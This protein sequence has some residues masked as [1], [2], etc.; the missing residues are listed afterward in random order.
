MN[1]T[2]HHSDESN[3]GFIRIWTERFWFHFT[4]KLSSFWPLLCFVLLLF[5]LHFTSDMTIL[6]LT[7]RVAFDTSDFSIRSTVSAT[8][9]NFVSLRREE[10][11][12]SNRFRVTNF[13]LIPC[14]CK[15]SWLYF[16]SLIIHF[17]DFNS[18]STYIFFDFAL[19]SASVFRLH[20]ALMVIN[21]QLG[22]AFGMENS[23]SVCFKLVNLTLTRLYWLHFVFNEIVLTSFSLAFWKCSA[24]S[25]LDV[26]V[27]TQDVQFFQLRFAFSATISNFSLHS[28][29]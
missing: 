4:H 18:L 19:Y 7:I 28:L 16:F 1:L 5:E 23:N 22:F 10:V 13:D 15:Y 20:I 21:F 2:S 8:N 12:T 6:T 27:S 25:R 11:S 29:R 14:S 24:L 17:S 26:S 9:F 3:F